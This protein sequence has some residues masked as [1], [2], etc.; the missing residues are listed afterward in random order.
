MLRRQRKDQLIE[1]L[2]RAMKEL[3]EK[4][5][6]LIGAALIGAV[7]GFLVGRGW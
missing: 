7:A 5:E 4:D 1:K 3:K 6:R 2:A